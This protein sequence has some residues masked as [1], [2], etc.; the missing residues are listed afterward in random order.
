MTQVT[1]WWWVRHAP[2]VADAARIYGQRDVDCVVSDRAAFEALARLLPADAVW[3]SSHLKRAKL[4]AQAIA[5]AGLAAPP[6]LIEPAL[7][8][9]NFGEWQGQLRS[10]VYARNPDQRRFWL[11][12]ADT[13]PPGGESFTAVVGRVSQAILRLS[14][15]HAGRD[16]IAV[17]HGGTIRAALALALRLAPATALAFTT[18][19]L[20]VTRLE[21]LNDLDAWRVGVVNLPAQSAS[22]VVAATLA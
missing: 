5:D 22:P 7:A 4:T 1:R 8:E 11:A 9:Q 2:V 14:A 13:A 10:E 6:L 18:D 20:A 12:P 17:A 21:H 19:N 3:V 16:I 15:A